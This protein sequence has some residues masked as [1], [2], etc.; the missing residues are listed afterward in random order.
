MRKII[1]ILVRNFAV[2]IVAY[3]IF[4]VILGDFNKSLYCMLS[5]LMVELLVGGTLDYTNMKE[6]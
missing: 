6:V 2:M 4:F 5:L 3:P 1:K